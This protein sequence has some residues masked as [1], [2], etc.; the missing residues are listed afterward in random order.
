MNKKCLSM[1]HFSF[2]HSYTNCGNIALTSTSHTKFTDILTKQEHA[3]Q[4]IFHEENK[5][6]ARPLLK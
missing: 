6:H 3:V 5:G 4:I 1:I 2:I